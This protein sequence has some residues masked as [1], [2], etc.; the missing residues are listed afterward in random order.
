MTITPRWAPNTVTENNQ[1][2]GERRLNVLRTRRSS[3][4]CGRSCEGRQSGT[5]AVQWPQGIVDHTTLPV[6]V[7]SQPQSSLSWQMIRRPKPP[8]RVSCRSSGI[9]RETSCTSSRTLGGPCVITVVDA[10]LVC[11]KALV[12]S[13]EKTSA[14]SSTLLHPHPRSWSRRLWRPAA[15]IDGTPTWMS[16]MSSAIS[17]TTFRPT[18]ARQAE[19]PPTCP[20]QRRASQPLPTR[21]VAIRWA[22][23]PGLVA[24]ATLRHCLVRHSGPR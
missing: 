23:S 7:G 4:A 21:P 8:G 20:T 17:D 19:V 12:T 14:T 3:A 5:R 15:I 22:P 1:P 6:D 24:S 2:V 13:S 16:N 10:P 18:H 11:T 9:E